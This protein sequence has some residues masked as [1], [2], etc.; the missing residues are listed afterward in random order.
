M[1]WSLRFAS[2]MWVAVLVLASWQS[3]RSSPGLAAAALSST[4]YAAGALVCHQRPERSFHAAGAQFPVCARCTGIYLGAC[5][6]AWWL[7]GR[8]RPCQPAMARGFLGV[9]LLLNLASVALEWIGLDPGNPG[10]AAA[11]VLLGY[12]A[13]SLLAGLAEPSSRLEVN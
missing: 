9:A 7:L 6:G 1:S 2:T 8:R 11:G 5:A 10:R 3:T 13:A 12:A 4:V